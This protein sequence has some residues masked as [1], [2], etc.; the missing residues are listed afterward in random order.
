[1]RFGMAW[2]RQGIFAGYLDNAA[3]SNSLQ[4]VPY[5]IVISDQSSVFSSAE[6]RN[7]APAG[8]AGIIRRRSGAR[9]LHCRAGSPMG[10]FHE[11]GAS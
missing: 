4:A 3:M 6:A 9:R 2:G 8:G 10:Y 1:M 11:S 5:E 7:S